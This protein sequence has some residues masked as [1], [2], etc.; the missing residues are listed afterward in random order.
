MPEATFQDRLP[1]DD[2][3]QS[4]SREARAGALIAA[5]IRPPQRYEVTSADHF[6]PVRP[7]RNL[8]SALLRF[9]RRHR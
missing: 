7:R 1:L 6:D 8:A 2:G 5:G 4:N 3:T 9:I